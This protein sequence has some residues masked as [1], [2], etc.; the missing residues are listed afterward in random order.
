MEDGPVKSCICQPARLPHIETV[1]TV[2][3]VV[4]D[5][6]AMSN[7]KYMQDEDIHNKLREY[8]D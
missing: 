5:P 4:V 6:V 7:L 1:V 8:N 2:G 3:K